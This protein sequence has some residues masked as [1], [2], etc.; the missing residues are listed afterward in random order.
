MWPWAKHKPLYVSKKRVVL[1]AFTMVFH[2]T[3]GFPTPGLWIST[4]PWLVRNRAAQQEVSGG[5]AREASSAAPHHLHYC[6]NQLPHP[7][8][9][10]WKIVF[11]ETGPWF[12]VPK[13][14]GTAALQVSGFI[15]FTPIYSRARFLSTEVY[16]SSTLH[17]TDETK[18]KGFKIIWNPKCWLLFSL[19]WV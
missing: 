6:L 9:G 4:G 16:S 18:V 8:P 2:S 17:S 3:T 14:L 15:K 7:D 13:M 5:W 19:P 1:L 10:P 11:H 12:L